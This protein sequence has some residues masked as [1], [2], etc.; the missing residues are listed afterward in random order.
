MAI[1]NVDKNDDDVVVS[2]APAVTC[3]HPSTKANQALL[4][5]N[6][7]K[8]DVSLGRGTTDDGTTSLGQKRAAPQSDDATL[9][10]SKKDAK[11]N[12]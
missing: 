9:V 8:S 10:A 5:V 7:A 11:E 2:L 1:L 12:R 6:D 3:L 4:V